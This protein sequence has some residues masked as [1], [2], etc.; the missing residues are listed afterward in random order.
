MNKYR[1]LSFI[2]SVFLFASFV[3][4][5]HTGMIWIDVENE[6]ERVQPIVGED[7]DDEKPS[8][9]EPTEDASVSKTVT[10]PESESISESGSVESDGAESE[11]DTDTDTGVNTSS[12]SEDPESGESREESK[13]ESKESDSVYR[14]GRTTLTDDV[15]LMY[16]LIKSAVLNDEPIPTLNVDLSAKAKAECFEEARIIFLSDYPECFWWEGRAEFFYN[17]DRY[18]SLIKFQYKYSAEEI[19]SMQAELDNTV[20]EIMAQMPQGTNFDKMVYLHDAVAEKTV[21]EY[22]DN[23]QN[24]YGALVE[25]K[26]VCNGYATAYQ[27]LLQRAG[28]RAWTVNGSSNGESHAWNAVWIDNDTCVYTDVTWN[29]KDE[30]IF[31]Y[32][33]NMS[34]DRIDDEHTVSA[35]YF[36]LPAC[37]HTG[38][39]YSDLSEGCNVLENNDGAEKLIG[40]IGDPNDSVIEISFFYN[41]ASFDDWWSRNENDIVRDTE[42]KSSKYIQLGNEIFLTLYK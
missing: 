1:I 27:L 23:D 31:H 19:R 32:Y 36:K 2:L 38:Y 9:G 14:Y 42:I 34:L 17:S 4:C 10:L 28:I 3:A 7:T 41:G 26:A 40:F 24:P 18:I 20:N 37:N 16:D 11:T 29:D 13:E 35:R 12:G 39:G 8:G 33:F 15:A 25:G 22:G 5:D 21:Y 6:K 30:H